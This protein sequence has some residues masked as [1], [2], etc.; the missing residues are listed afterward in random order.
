M[1]EK[2]IGGLCG[3]PNSRVAETLRYSTRT[4]RLLYVGRVLPGR[5]SPLQLLVQNT[6][7]IG[8]ENYGRISPSVDDSLLVQIENENASNLKNIDTRTAQRLMSLAY[9]GKL[10]VGEPKP[11]RVCDLDF[12]IFEKNSD[13]FSQELR[14]F[15]KR[16]RRDFIRPAEANPRGLRFQKHSK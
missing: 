3:S 1:L 12:D 10:N 6:N 2:G 14:S 5:V 9:F 15:R 8:P 13:Q 4:K 11:K 16:A 7:A